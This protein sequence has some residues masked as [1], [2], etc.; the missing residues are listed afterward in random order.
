MVPRLA[1]AFYGP[2]LYLTIDDRHPIHAGAGCQ[3]VAGDNT[4]VTCG[5]G[6]LTERLRIHTYDRNDTVVNET[7]LKLIARGGSGSDTITGASAGDLIHGGSG[8]DRLYGNGGDDSLV[9]GSGNDRLYGRKGADTLYGGEGN[10]RLAG[11][12]GK[13]KLYG[14]P[15]KDRLS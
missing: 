3:P 1:A 6:E 5:L 13:D 15:G 14:G 7:R 8:A 11:G 9:G 2:T 4:K 12:K 10:D